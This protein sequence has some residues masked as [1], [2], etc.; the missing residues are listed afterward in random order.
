MRLPQ[1]PGERID[2]GR[3]VEFTFQGIP[4]RGFAGDSIASAL[5]ARDRR[6]F[7]RSFKYHRPRGLLCCKGT[8]PNCLV[9]VDGVPNVRACVT[10]VADGAV[11]EAQNVLGLARLRPP[12]DDRQGRRPLHAGRLLLPDDD[13]AA[14]RVAALREVPAQRRRARPPRRARDPLAA[15]RRRAPPGRGPRDRG[16]HCG[17]RSRPQRRRRGPAGRPRRRRH[18][19]GVGPLPASRRFAAPRSGSTRAGSS[20]SPPARSSTATVPSA[21]SSRR[22]RSS[23]RSSSP[24]TTSSASSCPRRCVGSSAAGRSSPAAGPS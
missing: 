17:P 2:R 24:A 23:S 15:L 11:V 10:P 13:P 4:E 5:F 12:A 14:P 7:S 19:P 1:Q 16:Q 3:E 9:R 6:V 18:R 21:S 22:A 8:C 20:P